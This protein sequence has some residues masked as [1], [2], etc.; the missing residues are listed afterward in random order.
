MICPECPLN[1]KLGNIRNLE[2]FVSTL[3]PYDIFNDCLPGK[4][5]FS[6]LDG[7]IERNGSIFI[8]ETKRIETKVE[9]KTVNGKTTIVERESYFVPEGQTIMFDALSKKEDFTIIVVWYKE[10]GKP[11]KAK[12]WGKTDIFDC[13]LNLLKK[14]IKD[15]AEEAEDRK[16]IERLVKL[17]ISLRSYYEFRKDKSPKVSYEL[18]LRK[19]S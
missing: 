19:E 18:T 7:I 14:H 3:W 4:I 6:D 15:W 10:K 9:L 1:E 8:L 12:V 5:K 17:N 13:D 11:E 2:V 16:W